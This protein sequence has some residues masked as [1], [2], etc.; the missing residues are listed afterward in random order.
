MLS[1]EVEGVREEGRRVAGRLERVLADCEQLRESHKRLE[2]QADSVVEEMRRKEALWSQR[3][4][5]LQDEVGGSVEGVLC[6]CVR[7]CVRV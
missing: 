7:A 3:E 5:K 6:A 4:R 1:A 2:A